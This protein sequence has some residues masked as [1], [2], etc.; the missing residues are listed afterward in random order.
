MKKLLCLL[1]MAGTLAACTTLTFPTQCGDATVTV[2]SFMTAQ[3]FELTRTS[4]TLRIVYTR[5]TD[6]QATALVTGVVAAAVTAAAKGA[7]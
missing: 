4:D 7:K 1:A 6:P 3:G 2:P 5:G